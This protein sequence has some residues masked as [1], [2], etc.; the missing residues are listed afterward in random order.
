MDRENALINWM[1][2]KV[3]TGL[4]RGSRI[5]LTFGDASFTNL[6]PPLQRFLWRT[7]QLQ[8]QLFGP[9]NGRLELTRRI[10]LA[11]N[12]VLHM[13]A[14]LGEEEGAPV[15][16]AVATTTR[17]TGPLSPLLAHELAESI[18]EKGWSLE[19][20]PAFPETEGNIF[21]PEDVWGPGFT[22]QSKEKAPDL[23]EE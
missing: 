14:V 9:R 21:V 1:A 4:R 6:Y 18:R 12:F 2:D 13:E 23:G 16:T 15:Q 17:W 20:R 5:A 22:K 8:Q 3:Q 7:P 19:F 10:V 11:T